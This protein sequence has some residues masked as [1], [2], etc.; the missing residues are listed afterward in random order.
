[1]DGLGFSLL[2]SLKFDY[3]ELWELVVDFLV[4]RSQT[5][6]ALCHGCYCDKVTPPPLR[7]LGAWYDV[8]VR[9]VVCNGFLYVT[10]TLRNSLEKEWSLRHVPEAWAVPVSE[11]SE[12]P[13]LVASKTM[14]EWG[15]MVRYTA[16]QVLVKT[17]GDDYTIRMTAGRIQ[18]EEIRKR[19]SLRSDRSSFL[20]EDN[21]YKK[22]KEIPTD[23][24]MRA[25]YNSVESH[26]DSLFVKIDG[27]H[28]KPA[29]NKKISW[30]RLSQ[31]FD[32]SMRHDVVGVFP[33]MAKLDVHLPDD[34][35]K[36]DDVVSHSHQAW[37]SCVPMVWLNQLQGSEWSYED[38]KDK[39]KR[40]CLERQTAFTLDSALSETN[41]QGIHAMLVDVFYSTG[42]KEKCLEDPTEI[43]KIVTRAKDP[44]YQMEYSTESMHVWP[45]SPGKAMRTRL[46]GTT[47]DSGSFAAEIDIF[48]F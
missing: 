5:V 3:P 48:G 42:L 41:L 30:F 27:A 39:K 10:E 25:R 38:M 31:H 2:R 34:K 13:R 37:F 46:R 32:V 45:T 47:E 20:Y 12:A 21:T 33:V 15:T 19:H 4:S 23:H 22:K 8:I 1:M 17:S 36:D 11:E 29:P 35:W 28:C 40:L 26:E 16:P 24:E 6:F 44:L 9:G 43:R 7:S 14:R 18:S